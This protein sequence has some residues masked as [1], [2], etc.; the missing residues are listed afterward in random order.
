MF[1]SEQRRFRSFG[2]GTAIASEDWHMK[3]ISSGYALPLAF[4]YVLSIWGCGT[5]S[6]PA[7][8]I[9]PSLLTS[10]GTTRANPTAV[11]PRHVD[12][13]GDGYEDPEPAPM[14]DPGQAP[15]PDSRPPDP[16]QPPVIVTVNIVG[17]FGT[18]AFAP[19]PLQASIGNTIVWTNGDAIGHTIVLDNGTVVGTLAPGQSSAPISLQSATAYRCTIHPSMTGQIVDAAAAPTAPPDQAPMPGPSYPPN[20]PYEDPYDY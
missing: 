12:E 15:P 7:S 19:N 5:G 1:C 4:L 17:S 13:D 11:T 6:S 18:S 10:P 2:Y 9:S 16:G 20:D 3:F 8:P 14:P